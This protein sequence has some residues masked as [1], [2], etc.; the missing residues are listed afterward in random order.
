[1]AKKRL[2]RNEVR[3]SIL[4]ELKVREGD[5]CTR[6]PFI[7]CASSAPFSSAKIGTSFGLEN[8]VNY[9]LV[10]EGDDFVS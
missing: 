9:V 3:E 5:P 10:A 4:Y 6:L 7:F 2:P 8:F 1:M